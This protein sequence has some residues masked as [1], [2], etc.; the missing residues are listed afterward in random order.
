MKFL[1]LNTGYSFDGLWTNSQSKG[2]IFWFPNEQ[3]TNLTYTMPICILSDESPLTLTIEDNDIFSFIV[4]FDESDNIDGYEFSVPMYTN[5]IT[6]V[7]EQVG[8]YYAHIVNVACTSKQ[9]GEFVCRINIGDAGYIRVGADFYGEWE[10]TYVNLSNMGVEIPVGVQKAIYDSN[11]HEDLTDNILLNR[12]FKELLSNYWDIIANKGSYKSLK[13]SLDWFEWGDALRIRE[14]WKRTNVDR[15]FFDDRELMSLLEDKLHDSITNFVKTSYI[16]LYCALQNELPSYDNEY[17]PELANIVFK[18]SREDIQLKI[19]LLEQFFTT[20]FMP[21]HMSTLHVTTEDLIFTN[22]VKSIHGAET[23]R[24]D[25]IGDF[26]YVECNVKDDSIFKM[27]QVEVQVSDNTIYG[28]KHPDDRF[29]GVDY[30]PKDAIIDENNIKTFA[31]QR[32]AGPGVVIP[33]EM[34]LTNQR[35]GD[36]LKHTIVNIDNDVYEFDDIVKTKNNCITIRFNLLIKSAANYEIKFTFILSS[37]NTLTRTI[38][39]NVE[40]A[41]NLNINIYKIKSKDDTERFTYED[42][43]DTSISKYIY[44]VQNNLNRRNKQY[45]QYLPYMSIDNDLYDDYNGIKFT[46]TIVIDVS[47]N[48]LESNIINIKSL[49]QN[50]FLIFARYDLQTEDRPL[51]YLV[52]V[53]R[54]FYVDCPESLIAYINTESCGRIIRN[55]LGF[56]PQFHYLEKVQ[57]NTID[58]YT[59]NQYEA[60]CCAAEIN[61]K[62]KV[63]DFSS[64]HIISET[65][66]TY[67]NSITKEVIEYPVSSQQPFIAG[68]DKGLAEG[69]YDISFK[70]SLTNGVTDE[71]KLNSGFRIK[72]I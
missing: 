66:W 1:D 16:S 29:F 38:K 15:T 47:E 26:G 21:I 52:F 33:F 37:G 51:K 27:T 46:R 25:T 20:Y 48:T 57:G 59:L 49:M 36:F 71:C 69:Y 54:R 58:D 9:E 44:T 50:D 53:S 3:S 19:A 67:N 45:T 55:D 39:F 17:N 40:D 56:Y 42:F 62:Y 70:Y 22:T 2:Y 61:D 8:N 64:G 13:N 63:R 10:P 23:K 65:E 12:K 32:Y 34:T 30:Y 35:A 14:I 72:H 4:N 6:T 5:V 7:P 18:W 43:F 28:V 24:N 11:V 60:I 68:D 31:C 41:D